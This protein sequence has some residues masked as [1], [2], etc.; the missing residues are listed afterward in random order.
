MSLWALRQGACR[1]LPPFS[2]YSALRAAAEGSQGT[3]FPYPVCTC[4][5][6]C[7]I[8]GVPCVLA[9]RSAAW[10]LNLCDASVQAIQT[11]LELFQCRQ[12]F[13]S[14]LG[15]RRLAVGLPICP[16]CQEQGTRP[17]FGIVH[18]FSCV[19]DHSHLQDPDPCHYL[20]VSVCFS[21]SFILLTQSMHSHMCISK[22]KYKLTMS[23]DDE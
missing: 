19:Q 3:S 7:E 21:S 14:S 15:H 13:C 8:H 12:Q 5:K 6:E 18:S 1:P 10:Q 2:P 17:A 22:Y 16:I 9:K 23:L 11:E 20:L 4:V